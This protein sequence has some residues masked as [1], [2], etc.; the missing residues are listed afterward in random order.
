MQPA[1]RDPV[2]PLRSPQLHFFL[3]SR[4]S[5][6]GYS[7]V[8]SW[9]YFNNLNAYRQ[10]LPAALNQPNVCGVLNLLMT[11]MDHLHGLHVAGAIAAMPAWMTVALRNILAD[12]FRGA[13]NVPQQLMDPRPCPPPPPPMFFNYVPPHT[14]NAHLIHSGRSSYMNPLINPWAAPNQ[15]YSDYHSIMWFR[16]YVLHHS[17]LDVTAMFISLMKEFSCVC[18]HRGQTAH[19]FESFTTQ[20][21]KQMWFI[22]AQGTPLRVN[23]YKL[24]GCFRLGTFDHVP[25]AYH[26]L[27]LRMV[28]KHWSEVGRGTLFEAQ[29]HILQ[30]LA[31]VV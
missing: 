8:A 19:F 1:G 28:I 17:S 5:Q 23:A 29:Y 24:L 20:A 9:P 27:A 15:H 3:F 12:R 16:N 6:W 11:R 10:W 30:N 14:R 21:L 31:V 7:T 25:P 18:S 26:Q 4:W 2:V 13:P 22:E